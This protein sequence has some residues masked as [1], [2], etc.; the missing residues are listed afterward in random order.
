MKLG[1]LG[2][3]RIVC[4]WWLIIVKLYEKSE[5]AAKDCILL[6]NKRR[7]WFRDPSSPP[8]RPFFWESMTQPKH[9]IRYFIGNPPKNFSEILV[10]QFLKRLSRNRPIY[11]NFGNFDGNQTRIKQTIV[12]HHFLKALACELKTSKYNLFHE[13]NLSNKVFHK[14]HNNLLRM[15]DLNISQNV[16]AFNLTCENVENT[17][18]FYGPRVLRTIVFIGP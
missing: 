2:G 7:R 14:I 6:H 17:Y 4:W 9:V 13:I 15:W 5:N 16:I 1:I 8:P 10:S 11:T 12:L 3:F 18:L